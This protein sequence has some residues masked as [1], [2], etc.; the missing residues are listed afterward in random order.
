MQQEGDSRW[1][2]QLL[3]CWPVQDL[4]RSVGARQLPGNPTRVLASG[5]SERVS[6]V[7]HTL[8]VNRK[9]PERLLVDPQ[10]HCAF[11]CSCVLACGISWC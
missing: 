6:A 11:V 3:S 10:V 2:E 8:I 5:A 1:L 7:F 9:F 4:V